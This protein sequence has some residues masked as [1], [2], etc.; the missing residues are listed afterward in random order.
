MSSEQLNNL[1][2]TKVEDNVPLSILLPNTVEIMEIKQEMEHRDE[3]MPVTMKR[4]LESEPENC[5]QP[6]GQL[7][8]F[9]GEGEE[10]KRHYEKFQFHGTKYELNDT[11]VLT[12]ED[13]N[14]KPYVAI[15]KDIYVEDTEGSMMLSVQWF[16]RPEDVDK[17]YV[18]HWKSKDARELLYSTH[19]DQVIAESV[20]KSCS[21]Y[22]VPKNQ[23]IPNRGEY[24]D[25]LFCVQSKYPDFFVRLIYDCVKK[26]VWMLSET[27]FTKKQ[28]QNFD[29]VVAKTIEK[30][31]KLRRKQAFP[32]RNA[33]EGFV[34]K[35]SQNDHIVDEGTADYE[36]SVASTSCVNSDSYL[37]DF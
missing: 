23:Q 7:V 16:Y 21:V 29:A 4:E 18:R 19:R 10:R 14:K 20:M 1:L 5:P 15:I 22:F 28:R 11:V 33:A 36:E 25:F 35:N 24:P 34:Y 32:R 27:N 26:K 12:P 17:K 2:T 9:T 3:E 6:I 37:D 31:R 30:K 13:A 8:K